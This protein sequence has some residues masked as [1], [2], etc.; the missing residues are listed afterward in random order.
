MTSGPV[1]IVVR[2]GHEAVGDT[3]NYHEWV[4]VRPIACDKRGHPNPR[5]YSTDWQL[6]C[7]NNVDCPGVAIVSNDAIRELIMEVQR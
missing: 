7:C 4:Y 3:P 2:H 5:M 1:R 6:W